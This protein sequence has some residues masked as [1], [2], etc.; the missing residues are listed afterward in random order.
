MITSFFGFLADVFEFSPFSA[1]LEVYL[2]AFGFIAALLEYKELIFTDSWL[3]IIKREALFL[4]K[5][6]GRAGF[7]FFVGK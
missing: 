7:Y 6:Y 4:Y 5:P 2:F 3:R 1:L